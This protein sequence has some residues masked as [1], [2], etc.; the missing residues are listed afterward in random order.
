MKKPKLQ[1]NRLSLH[2]LKLV[3]FFPDIKLSIVFDKVG[4]L[5]CAPHRAPMR[6]HPWESIRSNKPPTWAGI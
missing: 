2:D 6:Q 1:S 5:L 4:L 3:Y